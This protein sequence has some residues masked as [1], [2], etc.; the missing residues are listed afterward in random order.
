MEPDCTTVIERTAE[1][2]E[3]P[4]DAVTVM[5]WFPTA[6]ARLV[7]MLAAEPEW[8]T[9]VPST[10]ISQPVMLWEEFALACTATGEVT[11]APF[12]GVATVTV[13]GWAPAKPGTATHA[14]SRTE[15]TAASA[16]EHSFI[17]TLPY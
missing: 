9:R 8:N 16:M 4:A 13:T 14:T 17:R 10:S 7:L 6:K 1:P 5:L 11:L 3:L 15:H 12:A 2:E